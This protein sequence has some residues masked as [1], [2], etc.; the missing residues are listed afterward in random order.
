MA[1][2]RCGNGTFNDLCAM[3][4]YSRGISERALKGDPQVNGIYKDN[5]RLLIGP[6]K[7]QKVYTYVTRAHS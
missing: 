1:S 3:A 2:L 7:S 4:L 6:L 5:L